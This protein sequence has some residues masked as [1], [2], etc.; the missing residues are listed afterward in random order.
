MSDSYLTKASD[1]WNWFFNVW[2]WSSFDSLF[3]LG[4]FSYISMK[5][6]LYVS[7][8]TYLSLFYDSNGK[9]DVCYAVAGTATWWAVNKLLLVSF[10][11]IS[12]CR[13]HNFKCMYMPV[14]IKSSKRFWHTI[15][16]LSWAPKN[17]ALDFVQTN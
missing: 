2:K 5:Q 1:P 14:T 10:L 11:L 3:Q 13:F 15:F 17:R 8:R 16:F 7:R 9:V 12:F 4:N 6:V